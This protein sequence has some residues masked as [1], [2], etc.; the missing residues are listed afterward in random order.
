MLFSP[1]R[2]EVYNEAPY[3]SES[4]LVFSVILYALCSRQDI[5]EKKED[6]LP[7]KKENLKRQQ[8]VGTQKIWID[9]MSPV[10]EQGCFTSH[11]LSFD[12]NKVLKIINWIC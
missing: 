8:V 9:N 12:N 11:L 2:A 10:L 6:N 1:A 5:Q 7:T 4:Y 3:S